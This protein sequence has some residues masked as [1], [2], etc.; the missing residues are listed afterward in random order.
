MRVLLTGACGFIARSLLPLLEENHEMVLLDRIRP[1]DAAFRTGH[2]FV[3]AE[4]TDTGAIRN[5]AEGCDAVIHLAA[6]LTGFPE[7]AVETFEVNAL[8][9]YVAIEAAQRAGVKRFL[10]A[11]SINAFGTFYWRVRG[12]PV[13]FHKMPLDESCEPVPEDAYSLSK[14]FNE[15]TCASFTRAHGMTTAALRFAGVWNDQS[16]E[17]ARAEGLKPTTQW[18]DALYEWVHVRD[19]TRGIV[20]ALE[21]PALP[22]HGVYTLGGADTTCPEPTM[23]ILDKFRPDLAATVV[24]PLS[25]RAPLLSIDRARAAFGYDPQWRLGE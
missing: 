7:N 2:T 3:N 25:G 22:A 12:K 14:W 21:E 1:E 11:S 13:V 4:L 15:L 24:K 8:G 9:T 19:L 20:Q 16:Y 17:K 23:D 10:C 6:I 18:S 5:A